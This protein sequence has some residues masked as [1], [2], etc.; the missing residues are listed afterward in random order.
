MVEWAEHT[1]L[2]C[3][4]NV[5]V[6]SNVYMNVLHHQKNMVNKNKGDKLVSLKHFISTRNVALLFAAYAYEF[7]LEFVLSF[8]FRRY[9]YWLKCNPQQECK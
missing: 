2:L 8:M 4:I 1:F 6:T 3:I 9:M 5:L 7:R